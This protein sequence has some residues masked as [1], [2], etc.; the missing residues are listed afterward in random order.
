M[1]FGPSGL[2]HEYTYSHVQSLQRWEEKA[3][4]ATTVLNSNIVVMQSL[5][6]F[7]SRLRRKTF[8]TLRKRI[9]IDQRTNCSGDIEAFTTQVDYVVRDFQFLIGR[10]RD[11]VKISRDRRDLVGA[12][13]PFQPWFVLMCSSSRSLNICRT[14]PLSAWNCSTRGWRTKQ[15]WHGSSRTSHWSI[16]RAVLYL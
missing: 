11:F 1:A 16:F 2:G 3:N 15:F 6:N 5:S 14:N 7:Y 10:A 12:V 13:A 8:S 4:S 9:T